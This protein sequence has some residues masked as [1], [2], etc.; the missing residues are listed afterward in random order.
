M[1][2]IEIPL[3]DSYEFAN[4]SQFLF[5]FGEIFG[6]ESKIMPYVIPFFIL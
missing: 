1:E 4:T 6:I 3:R 5:I 2:S